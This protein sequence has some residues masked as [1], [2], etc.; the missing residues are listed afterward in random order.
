VGYVYPTLLFLAMTIKLTTKL[1]NLFREKQK[2]CVEDAQ[3]D[4]YVLGKKKNNLCTEAIRMCKYSY[5][6]CTYT[7]GITPKELSQALNTLLAKRLLFGGFVRLCS[8][9]YTRWH[10][11]NHSHEEDEIENSG[12]P[13]QDNPGIP[14]ISYAESE[15]TTAISYNGK[16]I[17]YSIKL[18][19]C[20]K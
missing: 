3:A 14:F 6:G 18:V 5:N 2:Q 20:D 15:V 16:S 1:H 9:E 4:F 12:T 13:V 11:G 7:P 19:I 17:N 10:E 8:T